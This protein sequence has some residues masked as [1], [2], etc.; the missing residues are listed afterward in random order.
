M[1]DDALVA[2]VRPFVAAI[3]LGEFA[4]HRIERRTSPLHPDAGMPMPEDSRGGRPLAN[5][6]IPT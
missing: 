2:D 6:R 4:D 1:T 3:P 5:R